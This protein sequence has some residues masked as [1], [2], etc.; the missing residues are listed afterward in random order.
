MLS[1]ITLASKKSTITNYTAAL[2][3]SKKENDTTIALKFFMRVQQ[4]R[5]Y[6]PLK[7]LCWRGIVFGGDRVAYFFG[8]TSYKQTFYPVT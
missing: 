1:V 5:P 4:F 6:N 8:Q 2:N 7:P 3:A